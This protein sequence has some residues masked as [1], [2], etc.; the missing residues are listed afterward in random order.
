MTSGEINETLGAAMN[1][2]PR[3]EVWTLLQKSVL[4][5]AALA[6][7]MDGL[8][9]QALGLALPALIRDWG[10]AREAF[11]PV[12]AVGLIGVALG[13]AL[14]G[15]LGDRIGRRAGLIG[16]LFLM[17]VMNAVSAGVEGLD[18]LLAL[19]FLAGIGIG[20]AIPNGAALVFEFAPS[21]HRHFAIGIAMTFIPVGGIVAGFL[22]GLLLPNM[23]W[24]GLFLMCGLLPGV[25]ALV[26]L[27]G[28]PESPSFR[29]TARHGWREYLPRVSQWRLPEALLAPAMRGETLSLWAAFFFCLLASYTLFSWV[30][31]MLLEQGFPLAVAGVAM[32]AFNLGGMIGSIMGGW[33]I[34]RLGS[35]RVSLTLGA[36]AVIGALTLGL[37]HLGPDRTAFTMVALGIEGCFIGGLHNGLYT[38]AAHLYPFSARATGVGAAAGAGRIGA[39]LSSFTGALTLK[40]AGSSGYFIV[41]A[42]AAALAVLSVGLLNRHIP[43]HDRAPGGA[44]NTV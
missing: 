31:T 12:T 21:H 13:A 15:H 4:V 19:R 38:I 17:G 6:F 36:G 22:A 8:A 23:G 10:L 16:S 24:R 44:G 39:V 41:V 28:L 9:N 11:A 43:G 1:A 40:L 27:V 34:G 25:L 18:M 42:I 33:L 26:M 30:P 37:S 3:R 2:T 20:A 35:R 7:C 5:L 32:T 14:G 29:K